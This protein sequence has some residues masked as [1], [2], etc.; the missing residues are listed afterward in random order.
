MAIHIILMSTAGRGRVI[1][2]FDLVTLGVH[3][4]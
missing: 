2:Q 1:V 4:V 3:D